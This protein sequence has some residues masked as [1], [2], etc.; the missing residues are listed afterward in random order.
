ME[1]RELFSSGAPWENIVGYSRAVRVGN[2]IEISGTTSVD[3]D[4][5]IGKGDVQEQAIFI[6]QKIQ[7]IL[8][9]AGS[10][11]ED[12]VRTRMYVK[13]ISQWEKVASAHALFFKD[14]KPATSMVEVNKLIDEELL[15]EI[16][17]SAI[18]PDNSN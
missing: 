1:K 4:M 15:I 2:V 5:I 3:G 12:V 13:D 8:E 16:E 11:L 10:C 18:V 14:I 7:Q 17:V 6:F 9:R